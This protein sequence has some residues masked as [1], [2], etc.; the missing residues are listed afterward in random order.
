MLRSSLPAALAV[1]ALA[2][3]LP[4]AAQSVRAAKSG[5]TAYRPQQGASYFP[6]ER[7]RVP[8]AFE[9]DALRGPGIRVN[10]AGE[11]DPAGED[12][13][14]ELEVERVLANAS[15]VL[16]RGGPELALWGTRT[17]T[18]GTELAFTGNR[19]APL[20]FSG[21]DVVTLWVE[22]T[23]GA[24]S[25]TALALRALEPDRVV[26]RL[27]F[28]AFQGLVVALG[29]EDQAPGLPLDPNHGTYVVATELYELGYDVLM[30]DEDQVGADGAGVVYTAVVNAIQNR[31]VGELAIFGYSH[32]GGSTH[33]L[34]ERLDLF[35]GSIGTFTIEFTSYVDGV[36]NDSDVDLDRELRRPPASAFHA[37]HYQR[38]TLADFFLDGGPVTLSEP[39]PSGLDVETTAW[40][41]ATTH[42]LV[43]DF[44]EVRDFMQ[45]GL[46]AR[47]A[48]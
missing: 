36:Q 16:E 30:R 9:E 15:F 13:L 6:F 8:E 45:A 40:G 29:G 28:H 34:A 21:G 11:L 5:L 3:A 26:D 12:D 20:D 2:L 23:S 47:L 17:K 25:D 44:G 31:G 35:R 43:D 46:A 42:F 24:A 18:P 41:A 4:T 27:L 7:V 22:R 37:N 38:G 10:G 32:G 39:P 14:I 19:S 48:R 33:D 1:A